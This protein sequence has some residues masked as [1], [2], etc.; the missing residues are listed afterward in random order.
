MDETPLR[1]RASFEDD[2]GTIGQLCKLFVVESSWSLVV[3]QPGISD[4]EHPDGDYLHIS[5]VLSPTMRASDSTSGTAI[6]SILADVPGPPDQVN[7]VFAGQAK[8]H[9]L[10]VDEAPANL[11][12]ARLHTHSLKSE[13]D[14]LVWF[15]SC[16][17]SHT[18]ADKT[19][20]LSKTAFSGTINV[21]L[22]MTS[23]VQLS[24]LRKAVDR[25]IDAH[26]V[27][28]ACNT[29]SRDAVEYRRCVMQ[30]LPEVK[31]PTK[32]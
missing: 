15:C 18:V 16:H 32:R 26:F 23:S 25:M 4:S 7:D 31:H 24:N 28:V 3:Q 27:V 20:A 17:K 22:S 11:K 19:I 10:E 21:L 13:W 6:A 12:A 30:F 1:L 29:L 2:D 8:V 14:P 9:I 5:G